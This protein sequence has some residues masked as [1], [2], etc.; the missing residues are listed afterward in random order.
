MQSATLSLSTTVLTSSVGI[1]QIGVAIASVCIA[2]AFY[3]VASEC[4]R[5]GTACWYDV[6]LPRSVPLLLSIEGGGWGGTETL[7]TDLNFLVPLLGWPSP[8]PLP[9]PSPSISPVPSPS[10]YPAPSPS[11]PSLPRPP[12]SPLPPAPSG[13]RFVRVVT[14]KAVVAGSVDTF[15]RPAFKFKFAKML[16]VNED[17]ITLAVEAASVKVTANITSPDAEVAKKV[18]EKIVSVPTQELS[19]A[20]NVQVEYVEPPSVSLGVELDPTPGNNLAISATIAILSVGF[21]FGLGALWYR[22]YRSSMSKNKALKEIGMGH[23]HESNG[24][25]ISKEKGDV[26]LVAHGQ[27]LSDN[28]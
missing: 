1:D 14:F 22:H 26:R 17:L 15:D 8:P 6:T 20:L 24:P 28:V 9:V 18:A 3:M 23:L 25:P 27:V 5:L 10:I 16:S 19:R 12:P 11:P 7:V 2:P 13:K 4:Q 21:L